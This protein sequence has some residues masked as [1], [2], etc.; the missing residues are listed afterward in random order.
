MSE[1]KFEI[2]ESELNGVITKFKVYEPN[3]IQQKESMKV[4]NK[5]FTESV[6]SG[7][8]LKIQL[9]DIMRKRNLWNDVKQQ[10]YVELER[11]VENGKK[12]LELGGIKLKEA[13]KIA[14][15]IRKWRDRMVEL[16]LPES[17]L[18]NETAEG[19]ADNASFNYLVSA[20]V[21]YYDNEQPVFS[22]LDDYLNRAG[23]SFAI[24][25]ARCLA[26]LAYGVRPDIEKQL[27]ENEFL[28]E[29]GF[30]NDDLQLIDKDGNLVDE[31]DQII[32]NIVD[33]KVERK[34]FLDDDGNEITFDK[35]IEV[36]EQIEEVES[37]M[38]IFR[39]S[40][41]NVDSDYQISDSAKTI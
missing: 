9:D 7:A 22:D 23:S 21:V 20:C 12:Q 1:R 27:P 26:A 5:T 31:N 30:V 18:V 16:K 40:D 13:R 39:I 28:L 2:F 25:A 15:D 37:R 4:R 35:T 38:E 11:L 33:E 10:E 6:E 17:Q 3:L 41:G 34:P 36:V 14:I 32:Q 19:Q 8:F 24:Q 29:Y